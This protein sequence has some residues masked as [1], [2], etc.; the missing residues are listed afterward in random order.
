MVKYSVL[1]SGYGAISKRHI[2]NLIKLDLI[3]SLTIVKKNEL[4]EEFDYDFPVTVYTC[5]DKAISN[6]KFDLAV[7]ASPT[8]FH[9]EQ[10]KALSSLGTPCFIEKPIANTVD[11]ADKL[12]KY[13]KKTK[14]KCVLGYDLVKTMGYFEVE[15]IIRKSLLGSIWRIEVSV[16]QYLPDWR[17]NKHYR[18][19]VSA[20]KNLGGGVLRE[21]SHE[22]DYFLALFEMDNVYFSS[23]LYSHEHLEMNCE[24]EANISGSITLKNQSQKA[25]F[26]IH[27]N[28][29]SLHA[30]R[31]LKIQADQGELTWNLI[32]QTVALKFRDRDL[33]I[34]DV[35][36][37]SNLP[38]QRLMHDFVQSLNRENTTENLSRG[39]QVLSWIAL[40]EQ[41]ANNCEYISFKLGKNND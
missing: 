10:V 27:L 21:L 32:E 37:H 11:E 3:K 16:G 4:N 14:S 38:Y 23:Q 41:S 22:F 1:V 30:H 19:T 18:D 13:I 12:V 34:I 40:I 7:I 28:M 6:Q 2:N 20:N 36:E 24:N 39:A 15:K 5:F 26:S 29:L 17:P 8:N 31:T 25:S 9:Y 33:L 35:S